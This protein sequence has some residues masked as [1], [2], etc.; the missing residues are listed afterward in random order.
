MHD[1]FIELFTNPY[2]DDKKY[3]RVWV[4]F[5]SQNVLSPGMIALMHVRADSKRGA[6]ANALHIMW[7]QQ[8]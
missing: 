1:Y 7:K 3:F 6:I 8:Q 2:P 4:E 5:P